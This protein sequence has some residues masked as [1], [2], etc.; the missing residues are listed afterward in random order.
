MAVHVGPEA[1]KEA[2]ESAAS[3]ADRRPC[4]LGCAFSY[5][6]QTITTQTQTASKQMKISLCMY[7]R[8]QSF[9]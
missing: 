3:L 8:S 2:K 4:A 6:I 1:A 7:H 5:T 9:D